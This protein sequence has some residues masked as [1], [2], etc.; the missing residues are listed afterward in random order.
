MKL[1]RLLSI[2]ILLLNRRMVQAKEL[3]ERFEVSVRTIYRDIETINGTGIPIVTYQGTNGGIGLAEG[4]RLDRN[5]LTNDEL[6]AIVT[7]LRGI[8]SSYGNEQ[9]QRLMEK[10]HSV[11]PPADSEAFQHKSSRVLIDYSPW[12]GNEQ[13][14]PKLQ[15]LEK[16]V[17]H[18]LIAEFVY[19]NAD[20]EISHRIVEPHRLILKGKHWYL[21]AYCLEKE[22]FRLFK[23]KRMKDLEI[24]PEKTFIRRELPIQARTPDRSSSEPSWAT[25]FVLCFQADARHLAEEWFGIEAL[26]PVDDGSWLVKKAFPENEWL[27]R[28]ILGLGHHV[29][30]LEPP[31]L[32]EIIADRAEQVAKKY[33]KDKPT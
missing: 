27:Y 13:L 5:I 31:H 32:R 1:E 6:A 22:Q 4:Y 14:R 2:I 25:Q 24:I 12:D 7:A 11:V 17:D 23:L 29:E 33:R 19:S 20:G 30:V 28:F 9:H 18:C 16:A 15:L 10:I 3:A 26:Y 21:Q 8:S